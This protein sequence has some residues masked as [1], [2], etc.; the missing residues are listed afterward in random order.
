MPN[1]KTRRTRA[2][3]DKL[4]DLITLPDGRDYT[5]FRDT[6]FYPQFSGASYDSF[7]WPD[8]PYGVN[9]ND[10]IKV[11]VYGNSGG[12]IATSYLTHEQIQSFIGSD[13][14][15]QPAV[16]AINPG[17]I[18]RGLGFRRG[19][20]QVTFDFLRV[21]AGSPFPLLVNKDEKI[22]LILKFFS[23]KSS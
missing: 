3:P 1:Q 20:F 14:P 18:L 13:I 11:N 7:K 4:Y 9:P 6:A 5:T 12:L 2:I 19:R 22:F 15:E 23:N 10:I 17:D 16:V 8:L 21:Q